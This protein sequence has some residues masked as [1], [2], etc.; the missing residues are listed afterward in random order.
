MQST[1]EKPIRLLKCC[2][3]SWSCTLW[4]T[5]SIDISCVRRPQRC[6]RHPDQ[7]QQLLASI[8]TLL[9]WCIPSNDIVA[10]S[11]SIIQDLIVFKR[12][13]VPSLQSST[14]FGWSF[15]LSCSRRA[16]RIVASNSGGYVF[17]NVVCTSAS[18]QCFPKLLSRN[19]Q[20][21]SLRLFW[22]SNCL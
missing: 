12:F 18:T 10:K 5:V 13:L 4:H 21:S 11:S 9:H 6:L 2:F 17:N 15:S 20:R 3:G 19:R 22:F 1:T 7:I 14:A 16:F 8:C